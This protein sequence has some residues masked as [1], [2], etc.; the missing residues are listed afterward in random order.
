MEG[1]LIDTF[2]EE[3]MRTGKATRKEAHAKGYIHK[4][5]MFFILDRKGR[6]FVNQRTKEKDFYPEYYSIALGGHVSAGDIHDRAVLREAEEEAGIRDVPA[7]FITSFKKRHDEKDRENVKVYA[8]VADGELKL[9]P[10]EIKHGRF[11]SPDE[12]E[13]LMKKEKFLPET[14]ITDSTAA[15][16]FVRK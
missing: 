9:D 7:I 16:S 13:G 12:L 4:S 14:V 1:E 8:F 11:M 5:V 10:K 2:D 6:I 3:G 15:F